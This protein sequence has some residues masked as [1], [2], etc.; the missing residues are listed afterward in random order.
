MENKSIKENIL[1]SD[2]IINI[3]KNKDI[4]RINNKNFIKEIFEYSE[5]IKNLIPKFK[6][7]AEA[8]IIEFFNFLRNYS[9]GKK[10]GK[11]I[12]N[13]EEENELIIN[14]LR[15]IKNIFT[16]ST[17][18]AENIQ[19]NKSYYNEEEEETG[20]IGILYDLYIYSSNECLITV[21]EEIFNILK[22]NENL[23]KIEFYCVFQKI[24]KE[25]FWEDKDRNN[26]FNN[27]SKYIDLLM[28]FLSG[29]DDLNQ[30][31]YF[32]FDLK[33]C[34]GIQTNLKDPKI[35]SEGNTLNFQ[36]LFLTRNYQKNENSKLISIHLYQ[37]HI[38][39]ILNGIDIDLYI[40]KKKRETMHF[41]INMDK[42]YK[43]NFS[44]MNFKEDKIIT[45]GVSEINKPKEEIRVKSTFFE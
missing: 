45:I 23:S 11:I 18:I 26:N 9:N 14:N 15:Q 24:A 16:Q 34:D 30:F 10:K 37:K 27:L 29:T 36:I 19:L 21:L 7:N 12:E 25:Y 4:K 2:N 33:K 32:S 39:L 3:D 42:W 1:N 20:M 40:D 31:D 28:S 6:I 5:E 17:Q 13:E 22:K 41:K 35:I 8:K 44:L 38:D 43:I